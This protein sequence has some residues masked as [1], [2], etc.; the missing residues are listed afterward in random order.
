M[1]PTVTVVCDGIPLD[2]L[3]GCSD[4]KRARVALVNL[5]RLRHRQS[6]NQPPCLRSQRSCNFVF[7]SSRPFQ[8][9]PSTFRQ[10]TRPSLLLICSSLSLACCNPRDSLSTSVTHNLSISPSTHHVVSSILRYGHRRV[11]VTR[12]SLS[13][14]SD[15]SYER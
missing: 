12:K 9:L 10:S 8:F 13:R 11:A 3:F 14:Y 4:L 6:C 1:L 2:W 15:A 5:S 7:V